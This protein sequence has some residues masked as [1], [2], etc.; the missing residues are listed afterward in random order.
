MQGQFRDVLLQRERVHLSPVQWTILNQGGDNVGYIKLMS[1]SQQ[2]GN[3]MALAI[4][5]LKSMG[6]Q[7]F[8]LDLRNNPGGLVNSALEVAQQWLGP[9]SPVVN[10]LVSSWGIQD[11]KGVPGWT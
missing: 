5:S 3:D 11:L 2:A 1:F 4:S 7:A 9:D 10:V 8:I 6:A